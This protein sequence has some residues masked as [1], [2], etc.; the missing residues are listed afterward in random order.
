MSQEILEQRRVLKLGFDWRPIGVTTVERAFVAMSRIKRPSYT[1][2]MKRPYYAINIEYTVDDNGNPD[3]NSPGLI[4]PV[5]WA[6]W[7]KLPIRLYDRAINTATKQIRVPTVIIANNC[8]HIPKIVSKFSKHG[9][10]IRDGGICQYTGEKVSKKT[11]NIDHV[12]AQSKGGKTS[13]K[14]CVT[15]KREINQLKGDMSLEEFER[16]YGYKLMKLPSEPRESD[17]TIVNTYNIR[18]WNLFLKEK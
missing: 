13:Y 8:K 2:E 1:K 10:W 4:M 14:N 9:V 3:F 16:K 18:D 12:V 5:E 15:A 6:D 7:V 11:G 17:R